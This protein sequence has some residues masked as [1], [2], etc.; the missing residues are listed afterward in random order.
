M[1]TSHTNETRIGKC[2]PVLGGYKE[3]SKVMEMA[4]ILKECRA[5][6]RNTNGREVLHIS[7]QVHFC[8]HIHNS[9]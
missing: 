3:K 1:D 6:A 7:V 9:P 5:E 2:L 4:E 8:F